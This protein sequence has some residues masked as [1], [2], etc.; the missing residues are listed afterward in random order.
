MKRPF[1]KPK[2]GR[3]NNIKMDIKEIGCRNVDGLIWLRIWI[4]GGFF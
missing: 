3:D 4:S 1:T 2:H